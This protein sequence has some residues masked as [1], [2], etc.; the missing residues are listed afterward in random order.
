MPTTHG[1]NK[2]K[3]VIDARLIKRFDSCPQT[4]G[5]RENHHTHEYPI[6]HNHIGPMIIDGYDS[7][8]WERASIGCEGES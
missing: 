2:N 5:H 6:S 3:D 7:V 4:C 8:R 1:G